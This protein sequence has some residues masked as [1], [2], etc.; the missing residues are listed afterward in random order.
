[1]PADVDSRLSSGILRPRDEQDLLELIAGCTHA[2]E[3]VGFG[4]KRAIG[5]PVAA[6]TLA[7]D[8]FS[9][10]LAYEPEE[11]VLTAGPSTALAE[12]EALLASHSQRLAFEPP[13]VALWPHRGGAQSLGGVLAGNLSG[14]R[15]ICA[16]AARDHFLGF[17]AI[18]GRAERFVGGGRVVK[19]VTGYDLPKLLAGSWGTLAVLTSVTVRTA[20]LPEAELTLRIA[21]DNVAAGAALMRAALRSTCEVSSAAF[22]PPDGVLLRLEGPCASV[23]D[24]ASAL[25]HELGFD[26]AGEWSDDESCGLWRDIA[27]AGALVSWPVVWRLSVPPATAAATV[28]ALAPEQWLMDWGGGLIWAAYHHVDAARVRGALSAG[29]HATLFKAPEAQRREVAVFHPQPPGIA[30]IARRLKATFDPDQK[31]NPG[32]MDPDWKHT[33]RPPECSTDDS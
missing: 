11:L 24:R 23:R 19:N 28:A 33:M 3:P 26:A 10:V 15:R 1:M 4:S 18:N 2:L 29:G 21:A 25:L 12:I 9:G 32:R 16:G 20:P 6:R 30:R 14:S 8:A 31:L 27:G 7:L 17:T 22:V 5:H 13:P